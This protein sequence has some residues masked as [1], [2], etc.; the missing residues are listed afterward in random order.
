MENIKAQDINLDTWLALPA[1]QYVM[2]EL[3]KNINE[4]A[5]RSPCL[6]TADETHAQ[7]SFNLGLITGLSTIMNYKHRTI[8]KK[9]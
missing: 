7:A 6:K 4:V 3:E 8:N 2:N 1:T 5:R 9:H